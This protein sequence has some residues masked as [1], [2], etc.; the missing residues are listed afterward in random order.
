MANR[1]RS[2]RKAVR[3]HRSFEEHTTAVLE[4]QDELLERLE[5]KLESPVLNGGFDELVQKVN[6]IEIVSDQ[7]NK[8]QDSSSKKIDA[9]HVAVYDP[10]SGLYHVVKSHNNWIKT[11]N[12]LAMWLGGMFVAGILGGLGKIVYTFL[13]GHLHYVP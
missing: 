12:K 8:S 10:D 9:I 4:A 3:Y 5:K 1:D 6:K 7:L 13:T 11:S 2:N